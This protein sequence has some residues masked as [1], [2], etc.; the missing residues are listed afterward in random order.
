MKNDKGSAEVD[1]F[2]EELEHPL[3]S[4]ILDLRKLVRSAVPSLTEHI[5]WNAPSFCD[6]G[7][8]RLTMK[9][10]PPRQVQLVFHRDTGKKTPLEKK[11]IDD[12]G[13]LK[14]AANDRAVIGFSSMAELKAA[15]AGL[16]KLID[17][18]IKAAGRKTSGA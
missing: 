16:R 1:K 15:E 4:V 12:G 10:Y 5:K 13:M 7:E 18:W 8:D 14:W 9:L 3:K 6:D 2:L 11:M 17:N